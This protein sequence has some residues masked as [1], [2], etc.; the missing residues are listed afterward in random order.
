[1][2]REYIGAP[3]IALP[4]RKR[5]ARRF[6]VVSAIMTAFDVDTASGGESSMPD[7]LPNG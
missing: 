2:M 3:I 4:F 7:R 1:M 6:I 5:N